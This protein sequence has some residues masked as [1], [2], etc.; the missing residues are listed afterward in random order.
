M[1]IAQKIQA[2]IVLAINDNSLS[3]AALFITVTAASIK[4][5][6]HFLQERFDLR[7]LEVQM[8]EL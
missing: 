6:R 1:F 4:F 7:C 2:K 5:C 3:W 8:V